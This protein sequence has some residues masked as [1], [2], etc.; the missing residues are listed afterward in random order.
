MAE[1]THSIRRGDEN[2]Y[3]SLYGATLTRSGFLQKQRKSRRVNRF[4]L[5]DLTL[6][7][8]KI[9]LQPS[10][11]GVNQLILVIGRASPERT[12]PGGL[13]CF[14]RTSSQSP[15]ELTT[16]IRVPRPICEITREEDDG[17]S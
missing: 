6:I 17:F 14:D 15:V 8:G 3:R 16:L 11:F 7:D 1:T 5:G 9:E 4:V 12:Y 10:P 2:D 13:P